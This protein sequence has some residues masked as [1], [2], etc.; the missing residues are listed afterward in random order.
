MVYSV[1]NSGVLSVKQSNDTVDMMAWNGIKEELLGCWKLVSGKALQVRSELLV[2]LNMHKP[3]THALLFGE[4][5][6]SDPSRKTPNDF[7]EL[8]DNENLG[9]ICGEIGARRK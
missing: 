5:F 6:R 2:V 7:Y 1:D 8:R 4:Y 3:C 9:T